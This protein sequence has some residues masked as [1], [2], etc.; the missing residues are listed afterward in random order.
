MGQKLKI[1]GILGET[2][3]KYRPKKFKKLFS[4]SIFKTSFDA[5]DALFSETKYLCRFSNLP[6]WKIRRKQDFGSG[7]PEMKIQKLI[8]PFGRQNLHQSPCASQEFNTTV[9]GQELK[10]KKERRTFSR[11]SQIFFHKFPVNFWTIF[12]PEIQKNSVLAQKKLFLFF[13]PF[14]KCEN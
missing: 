14:L 13:G 1:F 11:S 4:S 12:H 9:W 6:R 7:S 2:Q 8:G 3:L 10:N 5:N